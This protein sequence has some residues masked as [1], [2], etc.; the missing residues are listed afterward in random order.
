MTYVQL[1]YKLSV[2]VCLHTRFRV[3]LHT[4]LLNDWVFVNELSGCGYESCC[5][6]LSIHLKL[7]SFIFGISYTCKL[8]RS[9]FTRVLKLLKFADDFIWYRKSSKFLDQSISN[10]LFQIL[11]DFTL[12]FQYLV[13]TSLVVRVTTFLMSRFI[14][15]RSILLF[16]FSIYW[17]LPFKH[18][19]DSYSRGLY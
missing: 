16:L 19:K 14:W 7:Y 8:F 11:I 12:E 3:N 9:M 15:Q 1:N 6:H 2:T 18:R 4:V 17:L 10:V 13:C 5:S